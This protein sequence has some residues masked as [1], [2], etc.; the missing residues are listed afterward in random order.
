MT[1][2]RVNVEIDLSEIDTGDMVEELELRDDWEVVCSSA[3]I[4]AMQT[5]LYERDDSDLRDY[6]EEIEV[7]YE[8]LHQGKEA[9]A[10]DRM[11][12]LAC[13]ATGRVL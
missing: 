5:A 7:I 10:I 1:T 4:S 6:R 8:L 12:D 9:A 11:R 2:V 3:P 13:A